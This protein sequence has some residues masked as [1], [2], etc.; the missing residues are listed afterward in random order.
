[1]FL[2]KFN[3]TTIFTHSFTCHSAVNGRPPYNPNIHHGMLSCLWLHVQMETLKI[4]LATY[5][6][7]D[8][9]SICYQNV[10]RSGCPPH[11]RAMPKWLKVSKYFF[12]PYERLKFTVSSHQCCGPEFSVNV[13]VSRLHV[14]ME[15]NIKNNFTIQNLTFT[16]TVT[17]VCFS[18]Q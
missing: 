14:Q 13:K 1:M 7:V 4:K 16:L 17:N 8:K 15:T 12:A 3:N 2:N 6:D 18:V 9:H 5:F 10:C 11:S